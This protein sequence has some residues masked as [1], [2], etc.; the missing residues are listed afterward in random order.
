M[1]SIQDKLGRKSISASKKLMDN[2]IRLVGTEVNAIRIY[3]T[4]DKYGDETTEIIS[5]DIFTCV[6]DFPGKFPF[7]RYRADDQRTVVQNE[8][9]SFHDVLPLEMFAK[10]SN[11]NSED[12]A[13]GKL[14][15]GDLM[16]YIIEDEDD[17]IPML[18]RIAE[19]LGSFKK[20]L[21]FLE[22]AIAAYNGIIEDDLQILINNYISNYVIGENSV[23]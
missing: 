20:N 14:I 11:K 21:A 15:T 7:N 18:F 16:L 1:S 4:S 10:W 23:N 3:S 22:Y 12:K 9:L 19:T 17:M 2:S 5:N 13:K 8:G 6:I